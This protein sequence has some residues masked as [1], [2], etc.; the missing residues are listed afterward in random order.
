[1]G[2]IICQNIVYNLICLSWMRMQRMAMLLRWERLL[3]LA[4]YIRRLFLLSSNRIF[5]LHIIL[6]F[7]FQIGFSLLTFLFLTELRVHIFF[8]LSELYF[9]KLL[10]CNNI[11]AFFLF[12]HFFYKTE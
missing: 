8:I 1:M 4:M 2:A 7:F 6:D 10:F 3:R 11:M 12:D 5:I 9:S